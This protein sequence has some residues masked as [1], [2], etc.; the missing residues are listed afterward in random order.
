MQSVLSQNYANLQYIV[1]DGGSTDGTWEK[2]EHLRPLLA[3]AH[4]GPDGGQAAAINAGMRKADGEILAWLNGDDML[5]PGALAYVAN[6]FETHADVDAIYGHRVIINGEGLEIGRW[7]LPPHSSGV[8]SWMD[9]V[10][11]ETMFL[12][13][14]TFETVGF[15]VDESFH[16]ALDWDLLLRLRDAG[17]RFKRLPRYLG[18]F[19]V[20]QTQK[21]S[22][23]WLLDGVAETS[24][25]LARYHQRV[26]TIR[27]RRLRVFPY[28]AK[29][30]VLQW[31]DKL[32]R[33]Y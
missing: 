3:H 15:R 19:R 12:R 9:F 24:R 30:I 10:P 32:F 6:F 7:V 20:H 29:H 28:I 17:T 27:E 11:Q 14:R 22:A 23:A 1:M 31:V 16:F 18:A 8:L 13:R 21:T 33:W 4:S 25:L 5:L 26:P 2:I